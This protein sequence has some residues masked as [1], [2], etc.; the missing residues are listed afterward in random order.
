MNLEELKRQLD[1]GNLT[2]EQFKAEL[3][4]LLEIKSITQEQHDVVL[5]GGVNEYTTDSLSRLLRTF[6]TTKKQPR[7]LQPTPISDQKPYLPVITRC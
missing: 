1:E 5:K 3:K 4:K 2:L 6:S 7:C